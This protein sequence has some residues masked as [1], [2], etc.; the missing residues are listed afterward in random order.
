LKK[1]EIGNGEEAEKTKEIIT[2]QEEIN[3]TVKKFNDFE[4]TL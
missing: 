1:R 4:T 3:I 2:T